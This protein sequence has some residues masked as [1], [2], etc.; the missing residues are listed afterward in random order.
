MFGDHALARELEGHESRYAREESSDA[1]GQIA[2][3][4]RTRYDLADATDIAAV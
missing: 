3:A 1:L 4:I 2:D